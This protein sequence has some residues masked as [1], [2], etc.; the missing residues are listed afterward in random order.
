MEDT[1]GW[2]MFCI[3]VKTQNVPFAP[4]ALGRPARHTA[5]LGRDPSTPLGHLGCAEPEPAEAL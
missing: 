5:A 4:R 2:K 3:W 1:G